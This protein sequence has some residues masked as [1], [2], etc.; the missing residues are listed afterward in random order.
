VIV[1]GPVPSRRLGRS[2]GI[3]NIPPKHCSYSCVY[4]QVGATVGRETVRRAF[5]DPDE[6]VR[7][8]STKVDACRA[9]GQHIDYL[10]FVPDGEPTLDLHLGREIR[11]LA[12]L[13]LPVAVIS[14]GSLLSLPA[15]RQDL[16]AA[17]L[18]SVKVD[19]VE[20]GLWRR[21]NRPHPGLDLDTVLGGV[22]DFA[23][24][25]AGDL[26]T[27]TMLVAGVNDGADAVE[28]VAAFVAGLAP[29]CAYLAAPTRP[30]AEAGVKPPRAEELLRAHQV[31]AGH[32]RR[33]ELLTG[34]EEGDFGSTG[35][36]VEDLLA[37]VAVHPM[38]QE[39]AERYLADAG[40]RPETLGELLSSGQ[41]R[42]LEYRGVAYVLRRPAWE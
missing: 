33:V 36:P 7:A 34:A 17:E 6:L 28:S 38:R 11:A 27:E 19:A 2:L 10:T 20:D 42:R 5:F 37:I 3:N 13:G 41:V 9:G 4:C 25:F 40:A 30:P 31:F 14:N 12:P 21:I 23:A 26:L 32:V 29:R 1:F 22:A 39:T 15:V 24:G 8:V 35:D 18:V 16:A